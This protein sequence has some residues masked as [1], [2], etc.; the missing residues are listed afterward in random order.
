MYR[1]LIVIMLLFIKMQLIYIQSIDC[2]LSIQESI[3]FTTIKPSQQNRTTESS[4]TELDKKKI[5]IKNIQINQFDSSIHRLPIDS[6]NKLS[7]LIDKQINKQDKNS[8]YNAIKV[9]S[10]RNETEENEK[11]IDHQLTNRLIRNNNKNEDF[12][13]K[14]ENS[15]PFLAADQLLC[16]R[17][18]SRRLNCD[19]KIRKSSSNNSSIMFNVTELNKS[20]FYKS[21]NKSSNEASLLNRSSN[22]SFVRPFLNF[23]SF[24]EAS[25]YNRPLFK[26]KIFLNSSLLLPQSYLAF[27]NKSSFNSPSNISLISYFKVLLSINST[28]LN[29]SSEPALSNL[30][31]LK[32]E[33]DKDYFLNSSINNNFHFNSIEDSTLKE[34]T[35]IDLKFNNQSKQQEKLIRRKRRMIDKV[36]NDFIDNLK[37]KQ[38]RAK[39][40]KEDNEEDKLSLDLSEKS[41]GKN[42][43]FSQNIY[44]V[45]PTILIKNLN[46]LNS[47][48][49]ENQFQINNSL[50]A[51]LNNHDSIRRINY[52]SKINIT[53]PPERKAIINEMN[54]TNHNGLNRQVGGSLAYLNNSFS[55]SSIK[56]LDI[57][58]PTNNSLDNQLNNLLN[59]QL[60][61]DHQND[62]LY[63]MKQQKFSGM[64]V[65]TDDH[66]LNKTFNQPLYYIEETQ[67]QEYVDNNNSIDEPPLRTPPNT[68]FYENPEEMLAPWLVNPYFLPLII[69]YVI[70]FLVGVTGNISVIWLML[71]NKDNRK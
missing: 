43:T 51:F 41:L 37:K 34:Q 26:K 49:F 63:D 28:S 64:I 58:S 71:A 15:R 7:R 61:N 27:S 56:Q 13:K 59:N 10:I 40:N 16:R 38:K 35:A 68:I 39:I 20:L 25:L 69:T 70:S 12:K 32:F 1:R 14:N 44:K 62:Q 5:E 52:R 60:D 9:K 2:F 36:K 50:F 46:E 33:N 29:S 54:S 4:K 66:K 11:S 53:K 24:H 67:S 21:L 47:T 3:Y 22:S 18:S 57:T 31:L 55:N 17:N 45:K 65:P 42:Q 6:F 19:S 48:S 8:I 30:I 23:N